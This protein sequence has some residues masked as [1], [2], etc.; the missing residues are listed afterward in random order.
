MLDIVLFQFVLFLI[1][2]ETAYADHKLKYY[3]VLYRDNNR[4]NVLL[5]N[6]KIVKYLIHLP[7]EVE[8]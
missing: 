6:Q 7:V 8:I 4:R 2:L 5:E 1:L 3:F